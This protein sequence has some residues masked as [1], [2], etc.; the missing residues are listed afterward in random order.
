M[1]GEV[2]NRQTVAKNEVNNNKRFMPA[3]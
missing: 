1:A 3:T 2:S